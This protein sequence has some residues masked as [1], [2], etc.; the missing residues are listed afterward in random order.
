MYS[1]TPTAACLEES[2]WVVEVTHR[3][4]HRV[5]AHAGVTFGWS[6]LTYSVK[7]HKPPEQPQQGILCSIRTQVKDTLKD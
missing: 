5:S 4:A 1:D 3:S 7:L 2:S 6:T